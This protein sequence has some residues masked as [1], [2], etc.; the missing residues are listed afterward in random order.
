MWKLK[1]PSLEV[2]TGEDI[3]NLVLHCRSLSDADKPILKV[4][5]EQYDAQNGRVTNG[6]HGVVA[7]DKA[8]AIKGQ[9]DKTYEGEIHYYLRDSLMRDVHRCPYCSINQPDTLDHYMPQSDYPALSM[10]RLN[11]VPMCPECNRKKKDYPYT[12]FIHSYYQTFPACS[13]LKATASVQLKRIIINFYLDEAAIPEAALVKKLKRQI[14]RID[15]L[16]RMNKASTSFIED[17]CS[18]CHCFWGIGFKIWLKSRL[19]DHIRMFG[20]NDWRTASISAVLDCREVDYL[21]FKYI[22]KNI[23]ASMLV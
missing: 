20:L 2:A 9:Y 8:D 10:C 22:G 19:N 17:L 11:L 21:L 15:L 14:M 6:Q 5:Y 16:D 1:K 18:Q 13:F 7:S 12:D 3:D 23:E 4:L